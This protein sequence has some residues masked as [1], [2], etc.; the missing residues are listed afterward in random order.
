DLLHPPEL[1]GRVEGGIER[2]RLRRVIGLGVIVD[3]P[4]PG[5][6]QHGDQADRPN[7]LVRRGLSE[8]DQL[9]HHLWRSLTRDLPALVIEPRLPIGVATLPFWKSERLSSSRELRL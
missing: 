7:P 2:G 1:L 6:V 8:I 3:R 5:A 4:N 9:A